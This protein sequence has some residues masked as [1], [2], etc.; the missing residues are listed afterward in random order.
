MSEKRKDSK[1]RILKTGESQRKDGLYQYRYVDI[2]GVRRTVYAKD[3]KELRE[4]EK[5]IEKAINQGVSVFE[6][7]MPLSELLD[8][9]YQLKRNWRDTTRES[10]IRYLQLIQKQK[11]YNMPVNKIKMA[12]CKMAMI[13][14]NDQGYSFGTISTVHAILKMAF[15]MA[16]ENEIILKNPISFPIKSIIKDNTPK[17]E[18]L[19]ERQVNE[20]L[21]FL[22]ND[23]YGKRWVDI[24]VVLL[25][26]GLRIGEFAA[27]TIRDIDLT[28]NVIHVNKQLQRLKG[29]V[30][31]TQ[32]KSKNG[33]REIP[34]TKSVRVSATNLL[35]ARMKLKTNKMVDGHVGFLV[36]SRSGRPKT[37]PEYADAF[38]KFIVRYNEV[39][40]ERIERFTPHV[41]RHTFCTRCIAC[42]MDIKTVQ[43]LMGHSDASTTLN[44]YADIVTDSIPDNVRALEKA[45][46]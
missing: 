40:D 38:R 14:L 21:T 36:T 20:L 18:A 10:C 1:G 29:R 33:V 2:S 23:T 17:V 12:D 4:K 44:I 37:G 35:N 41:L 42:G 13:D 15:A 30:I 9:T 7:N 26:T 27:L 6:G 11:I 43:Y 46:G 5:E 24:V 22:R 45:Y 39:A 32:T 25:G 31:I 3:L 19:T 34:M 16:C 28:N 8:K